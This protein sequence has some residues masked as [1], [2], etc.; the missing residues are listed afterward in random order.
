MPKPTKTTLFKALDPQPETAMDKT[1]RVV[2]E[3][4]DEEAQQRQ[5]KI[6]RLRTARLERE[7]NTPT[8]AA[9][10]TKKT[11]ASKAVKKE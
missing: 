7:A 11:R 9:S 6:A 10:A 4:I 3:I 8:D 1:T 2:R 5:V